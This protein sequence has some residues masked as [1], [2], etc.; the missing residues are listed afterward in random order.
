MTVFDYLD[1]R[2]FLREAILEK[3]KLKSS[4]S[5]R[6]VAHRLG[7]NPGFF[8]RVI[9][10]TRNLSP[11][12]VIKLAGIL[13]LQK[14]ETR[15]FELLVSYNQAVK[16]LEKEH[17]YEQLKMYN[18]SRI[19]R[20]SKK[21]YPLYQNWHTLVLRE[22]LHAV[23]CYDNSP[24]TCQRLSRYFN[25]P[26]PPGQIQ[27]SLQTLLDVGLI[28]KKGPAGR[29]RLNERL[30][31]TGPD[32]PVEVVNRILQQF[33]QLGKESLDRFP[34]KERVCASVTVSVS[35]SGYEAIQSRLEQCRKEILDIVDKDYQKLSKIYHMNMQLF[36]VSSPFPGV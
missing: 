30:T 35:D 27:K 8:N 34:K 5:F 13:K 19:S 23:P 31:T 24:A 15:Y 16:P 17:F 3:K 22:M 1:Y 36:P 25:P 33:F 14:K 18:N 32:I 10:G 21:Q 12:Y 7:C 4:F 9:K 11:E 29:F 20:I 26:V 28:C 2:A 6:Y